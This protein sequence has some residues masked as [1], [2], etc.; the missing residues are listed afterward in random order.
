MNPHAHAA[1]ISGQ[2]AHAAPVFTLSPEA[3]PRSATTHTHQRHTNPHSVAA[4]SFPANPT[5]RVKEK[6]RTCMHTHERTLVVVTV[7]VCTCQS[8]SMPTRMAAFLFLACVS[9]LDGNAGP[10]WQCWTLPCG[11]PPPPPPFFWLLPRA[12]ASYVS[13]PSMSGQ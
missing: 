1:S 13:S 9:N 7:C 8:C 4:A 2:S 12:Q 10:R 11:D 5:L 6:A 3:S